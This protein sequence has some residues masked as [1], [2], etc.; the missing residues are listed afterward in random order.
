MSLDARKFTLRLADGRVVTGPIQGAGGVV[1][2]G[3]AARLRIDISRASEG[4][5]LSIYEP[6]PGFARVYPNYSALETGEPLD[7]DLR[8]A[9]LIA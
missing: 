3:G 1:G 9:E 5:R 7:V 8:G 2:T 6:K 4:K